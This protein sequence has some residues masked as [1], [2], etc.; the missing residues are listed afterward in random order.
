MTQR[1][2]TL[3]SILGIALVLQG[4]AVQVVS[5]ETLAFALIGD[6]PIYFPD[7]TRRGN[8]VREAHR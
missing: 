5:A 8:S 4:S 7:S 1:T 2:R 3:G 6:H